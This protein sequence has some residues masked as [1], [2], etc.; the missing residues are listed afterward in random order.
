MLAHKF[1]GFYPQWSDI[2]KM[3]NKDYMEYYQKSY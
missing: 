3:S 1:K 2:Q